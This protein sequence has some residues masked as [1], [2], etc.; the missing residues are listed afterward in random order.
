[1]I[2]KEFS[3]VRQKTYLKLVLLLLP[4]IFL[5]FSCSVQSYDLVII[6]GM[7]LYGAGKAQGDQNDH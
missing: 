2:L 1:M 5:T 7:I 3:V 4:L 6:N